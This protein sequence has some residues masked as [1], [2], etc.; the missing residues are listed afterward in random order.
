MTEDL[1]QVEATGETVGEAKWSALRELEKLHPELDKTAVRFQVVSE[2]ERGLLGV[3]YAPARVIASID[4]DVV[5]A[6]DAC[7]SQ[8]RG[9]R[10]DAF[11]DRA[12]ADDRGRAKD[13]S[14]AAQGVRRRRDGER[15][16]RAEP[17]HR[18]LADGLTD[19]RL[20]RWIHALLATPGLTS[21]SDRDEAWAMLVDD[22]LRG[23]EAV[24]GFE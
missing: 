18:H 3:G 1:R 4:S 11:A 20:E 24:R 13:G 21:I 19:P 5:G 23:V 16:H 8:C 22:A 14:P 10:R 7:G 2:G 17:L 9:G 6:R 12:R 15:R